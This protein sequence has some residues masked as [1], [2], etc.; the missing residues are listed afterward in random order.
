VKRRSGYL[1]LLLCLWLGAWPALAAPASLT[2]TVLEIDARRLVLRTT[3][4]RRESVQILASTVLQRGDGSRGR[5]A[6]LRR[7]DRVW[8][9]GTPDPWRAR[10]IVVRPSPGEE[11]L[12]GRVHAVNP[13]EGTV[14]LAT[15]SAGLRTFRVNPQAT[16]VFKDNRPASWLDLHTGETVAVYAAR[17]RGA[18]AEGLVFFDQVSFLVR[19]LAPSKGPL[20]AWGEV[21]GVEGTRQGVLRVRSPGGGVLSIPFDARTQWK[22]GARFESPAD[23]AGQEALVFGRPGPPLARYV[24]SRRSFEFE[25][26]RLFR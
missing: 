14:T 9:E 11:R 24:V 3:D 8:I 10:L 17:L 21:V 19:E 13:S 7:G 15:P 2:G 26:E 6:E 5:P 25:F 12:Y 4:G 23:F 16:V 1:G 22:L 20:L 18:L